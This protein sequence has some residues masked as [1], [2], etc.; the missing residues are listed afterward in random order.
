MGY[1]H[2]D[3]SKTKPRFAFGYGLSY[4]QFKYS[5]LQVEKLKGKDLM[6]KVKFTVENTGGYDGSEAAQVYI[7]PLNPKVVRP[8]KELKGFAKHFIRKGSKQEVEVTLNKDAFSYYKPELK[9]FNYD[10]GS[11]EILVGSASDDI[12]LHKIIKL[13]K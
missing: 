1:R 6:V 13:E 8:Y 11:Y 7:R 5:D 4:T 12:R 2:Y 3:V 10:S 9:D